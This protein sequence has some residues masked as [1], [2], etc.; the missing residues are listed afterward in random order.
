MC[1]HSWQKFNDIY[2][3]TKCGAERV[4]NTIIFDRKLPNHKGRQ[5]KKKRR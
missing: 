5:K 3:C 4:E 1:S 2:Y